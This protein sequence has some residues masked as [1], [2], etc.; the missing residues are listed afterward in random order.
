MRTLLFTIFSF[1][2]IS[3]QAQTVIADSLRV[4]IGVEIDAQ[5]RAWVVE[6]GY[7]FND[8]AVSLVQ[9]NGD[10]WPV[11]VGLPSLFDTVNQ[12]G[13]GPWHTLP[14][15]GN[16]LAVTEGAT[17]QV[18]IFDLNG[19]TPGLSAPLTMSNV[20]FALNI[21]EF[22]VGQGIMES[23]PYS[24]ALDESSNLYVADAA[25]NAIIKVTPVGQMSIFATFPATPNPLPFGPPMVDAVPTRII[26]KPGGGFYVCQ[27]T[28]FPFLDGAAQIFLVDASGAVSTYA[29]NLSTLT[30]MAL[31]AVTG[32]L[33]ALQFGHFELDPNLPPGFAPNSAR[34]TRIKPNGAQEVVLENF[35]PSAGLTLDAQG[36][37][38]TTHIAT[39]EVLK[40]N[41]ITTASHD[42]KAAVEDLSIAPNPATTQARIS[43]SLP[44]ASD[45]QLRIFNA[46]GQLV[47]SQNLGRLPEGA[48]QTEW[49][50]G[51][52]CSSGIYQVE[53]VTER[54]RAALVLV[55]A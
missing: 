11:I 41:N 30:D 29:W 55:K 2:Y 20:L 3:S 17:G 26:S 14:L 1:C 18:L 36:N 45:V 52:A 4:P 31:D 38:Y 51:A 37:L 9:S 42:I 22:A 19:F 27:L 10:V 12:E 46:Q 35:G 47:H 16:R 21:A 34:V 6:S 33:Y 53:V 54:G 44:V 23:D 13:V 15:P 8:G 7:G 48:H 25:A 28:G 43:F 32:D 49:I 5:G 50:P 24:M 40:W 39:G